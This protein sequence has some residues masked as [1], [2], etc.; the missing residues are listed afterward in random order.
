MPDYSQ[1]LPGD[2]GTP[3]PTPTPTPTTSPGTTSTTSTTSAP[4]GTDALCGATRT[5]FTYFGVNESG[6]EFGESK[7]PVCIIASQI[8]HHSLNVLVGVGCSWH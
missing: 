8:I 2:P 4:T 1:C 3:T 5:K 6:A 7:I